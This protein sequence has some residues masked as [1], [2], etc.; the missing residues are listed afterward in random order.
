MTWCCA[1]HFLGNC[2]N[3]ELHTKCS[4]LFRTFKT[5]N[6]IFSAILHNSLTNG[7]PCLFHSKIDWIVLRFYFSSYFFLSL[8][9]KILEF[10][11]LSKLERHSLYECGLFIFFSQNIYFNEPILNESTCVL[12]TK[13]EWWLRI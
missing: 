1:S 7:I 6:A 13:C 12:W 8:S 5:R 2:E 11:L 3:N 4:Q 10:S 9:L